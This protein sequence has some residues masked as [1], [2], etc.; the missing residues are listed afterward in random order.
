MSVVGSMLLVETPM[1]YDYYTRVLAR[2][3]KLMKVLLLCYTPSWTCDDSLLSVWAAN[4]AY[5][6]NNASNL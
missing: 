4:L 2:L 5:P 3:V 1:H 6:A